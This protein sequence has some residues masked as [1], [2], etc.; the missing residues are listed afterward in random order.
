MRKKKKHTDYAIDKQKTL[1]HQI[2][3]EDVFVCY[4][5]TP[6]LQYFSNLIYKMK[7]RKPEPT[8]SPTHQIINLPHHIGMV[9]SMRGTGL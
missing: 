1:T 7:R 2:G 4:C 3:N 9:E 6:Q 5:C 8:L